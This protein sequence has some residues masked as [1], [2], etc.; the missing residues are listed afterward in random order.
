MSTLV[1]LVLLLLVLVA[2]LLAAGTAYAV[3]RHPSW[4]QAI[5]AAFGAMSLMGTVVGLV[6]AR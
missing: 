1:L 3:H 6:L 5:A 2:L 4:S